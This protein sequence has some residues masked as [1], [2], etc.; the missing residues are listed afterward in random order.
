[1]GEWVID[2][3]RMREWRW[4][5]IRRWQAAHGKAWQQRACFRMWESVTTGTCV[6]VNAAPVRGQAS[7]RRAVAGV[8]EKVWTKRVCVYECKTAEKCVSLLEKPA[9]LEAAS[10]RLSEQISLVGYFSHFYKYLFNQWQRIYIMMFK[11]LFSLWMTN[12]PSSTLLIEHSTAR[13]RTHTSFY[14]LMFIP[15]DSVRGQ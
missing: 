10:F 9:P 5:W 14:L 12:N 2:G 13:I 7:T 4:P 15:L 3:E 11:I 8:C 6:S 1:M